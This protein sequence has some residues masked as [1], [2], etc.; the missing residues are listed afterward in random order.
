ML[1]NFAISEFSRGGP[2]DLVI[3][4]FDVVPDSHRSL[5]LPCNAPQTRSIAK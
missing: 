2:D 5:L 4:D 3:H 1:G